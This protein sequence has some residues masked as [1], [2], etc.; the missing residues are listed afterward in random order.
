MAFETITTQEQFDEMVKDRLEREREKF[1]GFDEYRTK[2]GEYDT[3]KKERDEFQESIKALQKAIEGD[4]ENAGY[5]KRVEELSGEVEKYKINTLKT[6]IARE[7]GIPTEFADRL[8]GKD[9]EELRKD[10]ESIAKVFK[11]GRRQQPLASNEPNTIDKKTAAMKNMLD[12]LKGE[13]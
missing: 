6:A 4:E 2:A 12:K 1:S 8:T 3:V 13:N 10:A 11:T 9:E 5:K 7:K